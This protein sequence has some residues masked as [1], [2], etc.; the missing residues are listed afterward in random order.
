MYLLQHAHDLVANM[1]LAGI[2]WKTEG[3]I[4]ADRTTMF[5]A[6]STVPTHWYCYFSPIETVKL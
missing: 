1:T 2:N 6:Q 4:H 5:S 3:S